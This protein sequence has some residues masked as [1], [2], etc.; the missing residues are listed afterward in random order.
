MSKTPN[1]SPNKVS[2][3]Q[4]RIQQLYSNSLKID[5]VTLN[6]ALEDAKNT[7][8]HIS[9]ITYEES[10]NILKAL[11]GD[12]QSLAYFVQHLGGLITD[13]IKLDI[14]YLEEPIIKMLYQ[15]AD[16]TEV[17]STQKKIDELNNNI[18]RAGDIVLIGVFVCNKCQ[19]KIEMPYIG[20]LSKC[21]GCKSTFFTRFF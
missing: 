19:N 21:P 12:I 2:G 11:K 16:R 1:K 3:I 10:E 9:E 18:Y 5:D 17:E 14:E 13:W 15:I 7:V 6:N 20:E 8:E 4:E